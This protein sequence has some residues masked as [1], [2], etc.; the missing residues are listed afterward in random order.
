M[1]ENLNNSTEEQK[2]VTS[3]EVTPTQPVVKESVEL[4]LSIP[5]PDKNMIDKI[6]KGAMGLGAAALL[7]VGGMNFMKSSEN[8]V[9][10]F[11]SQI[12]KIEAEKDDFISKED[13]SAGSA[14][15]EFYNSKE[16]EF[17]TKLSKLREEKDAIFKDKNTE[18]EKNK[19]EGSSDKDKIAEIN[20]IKSK[21]SFLTEATDTVS[22]LFET[23]VEN[24]IS[25]KAEP[26]LVYKN[27]DG[28]S[29]IQDP[30]VLINSSLIKQEYPKMLSELESFGNVDLNGVTTNG[31]KSESLTAIKENIAKKISESEGTQEFKN[32]AVKERY[33]LIFNKI[34][35][36]L[37]GDESKRTEVMDFLK[38]AL[39]FEMDLQAKAAPNPESG[40]WIKDAFEDKKMRGAFGGVLFK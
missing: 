25:G 28:N 4:K 27:Q 24:Q 36:A 2:V 5:K 31:Q 37:E 18:L 32:D 1:S 11:D 30:A 23:M 12:K 10:D 22:S 20:K 33:D 40:N 34:N 21:L 17:D 8:K 6:K 38:N 3:Q 9:A 29:V 35:E 39:K 19:S 15:K 13:S 14:Q 7:T 16:A 26:V